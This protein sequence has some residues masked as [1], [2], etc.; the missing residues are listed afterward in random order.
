MNNEKMILCSVP[1]SDLI[2]PM[3]APAVLKGVSEAAGHKITTY[4]LTVDLRN[5]YEDHYQFMIDQEYFISNSKK[6]DSIHEFIVESATWLAE[7]DYKY[8]GLSVFSI[9]SQQCI[10]EL[11]KL[12][13][14]L[15][16]LK[17]IVIGGRGC[18]HAIAQNVI[19]HNH[20][21]SSDL[22]SEYMLEQKLVD[23]AICGDGED[24]LVSFLDTGSSDLTFHESPTKL[25]YPYPNFDDY[26]FNAYVGPGGVKQIPVYSS[27]GCVRDCDFCD[28]RA[29]FNKF[30]SKPGSRLADELIYLSN[31]YN[32][33]SFTLS[34][35]ISNGN[36]VAL[37]ETMS[38]LAEH[39]KTHKTITWNG[40]WICRPVGQIPVEFYKELK[41][42]G[43]DTL[44]VGAEHGSTSVLEA[45]DKK[46]SAE[47]LWYELEQFSKNGIQCSLNFIGGH[48]S[49]TWDDFLI[50]CKTMVGLQ[51]YVAS[52]TV[53]EI[54]LGSGFLIQ[55]NTPAFNDRSKNKLEVYSDYNWNFLWKTGANPG[56]TLKERDYR[57][58]ILYT[59]VQTLN[60]PADFNLDLLR[61]KNQLL[62]NKEVINEF[63][64]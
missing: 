6:S 50:Q 4:D 20:I 38:R 24:A 44:T 53:V 51:K 15:N 13:R 61:I 7:S 57:Q 47:A 18:G 37:R 58:M 43:C 48:W 52:K 36:M 10:V 19:D 63:F 27:K 62:D 17:T 14:E 11:C 2:I 35:S 9:W 26:D 28:V 40:N 39:N 23:H 31:R 21:T 3:A 60:L 8:I 1:Y 25:E 5:R 22:F 12:I 55:S 32:I 33:Y 30:K 56:L 64:S 59:I 54:N 42:S 29:L 41:E 46:T 45:M 49:E 16:P 34:D